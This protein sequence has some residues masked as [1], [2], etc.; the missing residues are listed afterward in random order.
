MSEPPGASFSVSG[1]GERLDYAALVV[2]P[3][4]HTTYRPAGYAL[5]VEARQ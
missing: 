3:M 4:T 1:F 5:R 2:A